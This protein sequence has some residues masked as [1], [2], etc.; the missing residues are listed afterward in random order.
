MQPKAVGR[1]ASKAQLKGKAFSKLLLMTEIGWQVTLT[2]INLR[3]ET[4]ERAGNELGLR[5]SQLEDRQSNGNYSI[6]SCK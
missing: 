6:L 3:T 4:L 2:D 5:K 1:L